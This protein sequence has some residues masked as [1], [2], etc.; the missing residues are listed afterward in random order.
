MSWIREVPQEIESGPGL[1]NAAVFQVL[2]INPDAQAK[3]RALVS[4][5]TFG[6]S[7]LNSRSRRSDC[8][9]SISQQ[10]LP[11]LNNSPRS[12]AP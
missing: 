12:V 6:G 9:S 7:I 1:L 3:L 2:S 8:N 10:P 5:T 4:A 11:I